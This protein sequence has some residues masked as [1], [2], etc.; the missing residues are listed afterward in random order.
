[1]SPN[2]VRVGTEVCCP[3]DRP[4]STAGTRRTPRRSAL[5][6]FSSRPSRTDSMRRPDTLTTI[7]EYCQAENTSAMINITLLTYCRAYLLEPRRLR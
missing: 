4:E 6:P 1:M 3:V 7:S 5:C 2:P